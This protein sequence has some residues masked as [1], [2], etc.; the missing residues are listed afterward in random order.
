M[1]VLEQFEGITSLAVISPRS[2]GDANVA[3]SQLASATKPSMLL[4]FFLALHEAP[5]KVSSADT[6]ICW[7][8]PGDFG[9]CE[10]NIPIECCN[11]HLILHLDVEG[12]A[13]NVAQSYLLLSSDEYAEPLLRDSL[14][15]FG[16][17]RHPST[18]LI[19]NS[20]DGSLLSQLRQKTKQHL[21]TEG[22]SL[23]AKNLYRVRIILPRAFLPEP[24]H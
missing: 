14:S 24:I 22:F 10:W 19:N 16:F 9:S 1:I 17:T 4:Q 20:G 8:A 13:S 7:G 15:R 21:V 11:N 2:M 3:Q 23:I 12:G 6:V 18:S 5:L